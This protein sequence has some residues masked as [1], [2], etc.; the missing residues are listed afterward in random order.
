MRQIVVGVA[1]ALSLISVLGTSGCASADP[2]TEAQV[3]EFANYAATLQ[4]LPGVEQVDLNTNEQTSAA[5]LTVHIRADVEA[6][7]LA[8]IGASVADFAPTAQERGYVPSEP[9]I[10]QGESTFSYFDALTDEA[11]ADQLNYWMEL[12]LAGVNAVQMRTYTSLASVPAIGGAGETGLVEEESEQPPRYVLVDLPTDIAE[13]DLRILIESLAV[14]PDPGA[15]GGQWDFLNL[16]PRTKGEY[17]APHFPSI[18][19]L[20]Y[21]VTT[22][23]HFADVDGLASVEILRDS[24]H[25]TPLRIRIAVFDDA[26]DGVGSKDAEAMFSQTE[27]WAHLLDLVSLLEGAGALDYGVQVLANPL[28]DGG[29]FQ[30]KFGVHGCEFEPDGRWPE[31]SADLTWA[32]EENAADERFESDPT[33]VNPDSDDQHGHD[34]EHGD[35]PSDDEESA[36]SDAE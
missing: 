14:L 27:A 28:N 11:V 21:A 10:R 15:P 3:D 30:L 26:M 32:W 25:D 20:S 31:L 17:A 24:G 7:P 12:Q 19:E 34:D 8:D 22:G 23:N 6:A 35:G 4:N 33:C 1:L 5:S 9:V 13:A 36:E 2:Q 18:A 16:A 29:N